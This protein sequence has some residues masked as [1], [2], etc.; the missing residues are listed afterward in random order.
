MNAQLDPQNETHELAK[1]SFEEHVRLSH[2][3]SEVP[4]YPSQETD[5]EAR[6][7]EKELREEMH[8]GWPGDGS[9][10]DDFADMNQNEAMDYCNE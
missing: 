9:G 7:E 8:G 4:E 2:D 3:E 5:V 10:E 6:R 1:E